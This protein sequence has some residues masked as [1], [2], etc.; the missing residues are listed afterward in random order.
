VEIVTIVTI[1]T[2]VGR[3]GTRAKI[4]GNDTTAEM[5]RVETKGI[6]RVAVMIFR[7]IVPKMPNRMT[8]IR[9][10]RWQ[11]RLKSRPSLAPRERGK[12]TMLVMLNP[13]PRRPG[14]IR[15]LKFEKVL[16]NCLALVFGSG[17]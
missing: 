12:K 2:E 4:E 5:E 3:K 10:M 8:K 1:R 11:A 17:V 15:V 13:R 16:S 6:G 14:L 7:R 9:M